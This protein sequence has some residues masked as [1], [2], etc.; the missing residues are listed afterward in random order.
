[1]INKIEKCSG[2]VFSSSTRWW[3]MLWQCGTVIDG[4]CFSKYAEVHMGK[5]YCVNR[6]SNIIIYTME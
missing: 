5:G 4:L 2:F 1:M 3:N 6:K